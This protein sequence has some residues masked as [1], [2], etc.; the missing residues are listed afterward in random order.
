MAQLVAMATISG[1]LGAPGTWGPY[2]RAAVIAVNFDDTSVQ[3]AVSVGKQGW[4]VSSALPRL[5]CDGAW[6]TLA[7]LEPP[8]ANTSVDPRL[9]PTATL[10]KQWGV[11]KAAGGACG[12]PGALMTTT[13]A[14]YAADDT[15]EFTTSFPR[16]VGSTGGCP[17]P[18]CAGCKLDDLFGNA[19]KVPLSE[20]PSFK[21]GPG[22]ALHDTLGWWQWG[23]GFSQYRTGGGVGLKRRESGQKRVAGEGKGLV[24]GQEG[25]PLVLFEAGK[26]RG[27]A[28]VLSPMSAWFS[29]MLGISGG[30]STSNSTSADALGSL[31]AGVQGGVTSIPKGHSVSFAIVATVA[32]VS[33]STSSGVNAAVE[34]WGG[35]LRKKYGTDK[36]RYATDIVT[37]KLG[38]WTDNGGYFYGTKYP[39]SGVNCVGHLCC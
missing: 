30:G 35:V 7:L 9:G 29:A 13:I 24:G 38:Y 39:C 19:T 11:A 5:F 23:G 17:Q 25:G 3:Y 10:T 14:Y 27:A 1:A 8:R 2:G 12:G 20:F 28:L 31:V 32:G 36:S 21:Q 34:C 33:N 26:A 16:G 15:L 4:L 18:S 37:N 22:T 6:R